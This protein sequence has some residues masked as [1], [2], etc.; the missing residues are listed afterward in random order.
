MLLENI[1]R[2][3]ITHDS[4]HLRLHIILA[5]ATGQRKVRLGQ[6]RLGSVRFGS[7]RFGSV[8]IGWVRLG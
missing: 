6:V 3:D 1:Y 7:V 2:T 8:Q 4:H 5:P